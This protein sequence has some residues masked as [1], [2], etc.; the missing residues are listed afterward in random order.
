[1]ERTILVCFGTNLQ[2]TRVNENYRVWQHL[3][4]EV[5]GLYLLDCAVLGLE[6]LI[7]LRSCLGF[8]GIDGLCLAL[9]LQLPEAVD[10]PNKSDY[11]KG[12]NYCLHSKAF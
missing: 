6:G 11:N 12:K 5:Y 10:S 1:M 2:V 7:F 8:L 3:A 9:G 4:F